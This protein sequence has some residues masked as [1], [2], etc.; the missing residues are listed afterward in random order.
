M[1][2]KFVR[3]IDIEEDEE[4][5]FLEMF[6]KKLFPRELLMTRIHIYI[7]NPPLKHFLGRIK[8][9]VASRYSYC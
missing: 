5:D 9:K 2:E 7:F 3:I 4:N 6:K 8:V 1:K